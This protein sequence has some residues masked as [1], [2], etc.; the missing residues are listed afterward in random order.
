MKDYIKEVQLYRK[1]ANRMEKLGAD[2]EA[3]PSN[4]EVKILRVSGFDVKY[5]YGNKVKTIRLYGDKNTIKSLP[6]GEQIDII[7]QLDNDRQR[8][9]FPKAA[10][11]AA[12]KGTASRLK[13][14]GSRQK[15]IIKDAKSFVK[16]FGL[17]VDD[18]DYDNYINFNSWSLED[19]E[20][21]NEFYHTFGATSDNPV[22]VAAY[23]IW[24]EQQG[25]A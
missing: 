6:K 1:A 12:Q 17:N 20:S 7:T 21:K 25:M 11:Q 10:V 2:R 19:S 24:K 15:A 9:L 8:T 16:Q 14:G 23:T 22:S 3:I 13:A 18:I 5:Q 4:K